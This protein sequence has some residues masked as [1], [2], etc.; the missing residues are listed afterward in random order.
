M[1][2]AQVVQTRCDH[3]REVREPIFGIAQDIFDDAR[4]LDSGDGM[5]NTHAYA[6][7]ALVGLSLSVRQLTLTRLFFGWYV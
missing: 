3:H 7:D 5:F 2:H 4:A 6:R 1:V